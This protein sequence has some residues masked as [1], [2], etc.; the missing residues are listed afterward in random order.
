MMISTMMAS[1][2]SAAR[3]LDASSYNAQADDRKLAID[4]STQQRHAEQ[5]QRGRVDAREIDVL[6]Y[7]QRVVDLFGKFGDFSDQRIEAARQLGETPR[8]E[9]RCRAPRFL[10][11]VVH[12]RELRVE[13]FVVVAKLEQLRIGDFEHVRDIGIAARLVDESAIPGQHDEIVFVIR[14]RLAQHF[15]TRRIR[16][17]ASL[18]RKD[19]HEVDL[20]LHRARR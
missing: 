15:A 12:A 7:L 14:E 9:K 10:D 18:A 20:Q 3:L 8:G 6:G 13:Q 1:S 11:T 17:R 16:Q 19:R 2:S 4:R 5:R